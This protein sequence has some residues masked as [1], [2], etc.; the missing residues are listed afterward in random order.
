MNQDERALASLSRSTRPLKTIGVTLVVLGV[1]A[2]VFAIIR[3]VNAP[4]ELPMSAEG[5]FD[6]VKAR[7]DATSTAFT[8]GAVGVFV[9]FVGAQL[10][11]VASRRVQRMGANLVTAAA[12][13]VTTG[14]EGA[15]PTS[16]AGPRLAELEELKR[17]ELISATEYETRRAAILA[18]L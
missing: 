9:V 1:L 13:A 15:E 6:S 18:Q 10:V 4:A 14:L 12:A 16:G 3:Y 5:W 8:S 17:R 7:S 11:L 2:I